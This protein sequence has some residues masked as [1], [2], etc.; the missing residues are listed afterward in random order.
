[1]MFLPASLALA[2]KRAAA[3]SG[4]VSLIATT[5]GAV[6]NDVVVAHS[7]PPGIA[8][9][10]AVFA[11]VFAT[12]TLTPPPGWSLVISQ[13]TVGAA[14]PRTAYIYRK[15]SVSSGDSSTSYSWSQSASGRIGVA[16]CVARSNTGT[17]THAQSEGLASNT[18]TTATGSVNAACP[19]L[20]ASA[21][22][23][24]FILMAVSESANTGGNTWTAPTGSTRFTLSAQNNWRL[25]AATQARDNGQSNSS[26]FTVGLF[27]AGTYYFTS[28]ALRLQAT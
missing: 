26:P 2:V 5:G 1:M 23:E 19:T 25:A 18:T 11:T 7:T 13:T 24:L 6:A 27:A 4:V 20:T 14:F 10:D 17:V 22:G 3:S 9:N 12:S 21:D 16:Y 15:D 8:A 28:L